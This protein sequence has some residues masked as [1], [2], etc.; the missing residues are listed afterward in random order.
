LTAKTRHANI[1][2]I[3]ALTLI[4]FIGDFYNSFVIPL[5]PLFV[6]KFSLSLT[7]AGLITGLS[8]FWAFMV[9]PPVGYLA[10]RHRT[11]IFAL[12]G[13]LLVTVFISLTGI[14]PNFWILLLFV[15]LG[16]IGSSMFHPTTAGM[17]EPH[18]GRNFGLAMAIFG[19]GGTLAFG[20]GPLFI[21]WF[22][23]AYGLHAM[24]FAMILG[25]AV[26]IYLYYTVPVPEVQNFRQHS[27][28]QSIKEI[29][30]PVWLPVLLI[31]LVMTLR[32][33]VSQSFLT[34]LPLLYSQ[35]GLSL[36]SIGTLVSLF[37]VGGALSGL[38]AGHLSDKVGFKPV[39][40]SAH[41]LTTPSMFLLLYLQGNWIYPGVFL[42]GF[43]VLATLPLGVALAQK[44]APG[45][46]SM[47]SSLMMGLAY[48]AGG[49]LTPLTGKLADIFSLR[50]V[51]SILAFIPILSI[52]LIYYLF[53]Q[54]STSVSR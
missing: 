11:R 2:I 20:V 54:Y 8:R 42:T 18:S 21:S 23:A 51:L 13:P 32:A 9:Q 7:Q 28:F 1:K 41:L 22:V 48:G 25:L 4:H 5:L 44:M 53:K 27:L 17:I 43:F 6:A 45:G 10:D 19:T 29:F 34:Y 24:P 26:M 38:L 3:F 12:G 15:C 16:S 47:A 37:T 30:G 35:K 33:Y 36:L 46:K 49:L 39:F 52:T 40:V 50:P 14:A 31:W